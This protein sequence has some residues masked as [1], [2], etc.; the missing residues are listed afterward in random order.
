[1]LLLAYLLK[2]K[3]AQ[4][5]KKETYVILPEGLSYNNQDITQESNC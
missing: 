4:K 3:R 5:R 1:M 2:E